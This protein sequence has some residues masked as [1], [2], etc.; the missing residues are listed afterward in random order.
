M[1]NDVSNVGQNRRADARHR[2]IGDGGRRRR[3]IRDGDG[4]SPA[5]RRWAGNVRA[6]VVDAVETI[7]P[8]PRKF[9]EEGGLGEIHTRRPQKHVVEIRVLDCRDDPEQSR[10]DLRIGCLRRKPPSQRLIHRH[11]TRDD[12][13]PR[14]CGDDRLTTARS[15]VRFDKPPHRVGDPQRRD[16]LNN[17]GRDQRINHQVE[18]DLGGAIDRNVFAL[19]GNI[20]VAIVRRQS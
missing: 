12:E 6:K 15:R 20:V 11:T 10:P 3:E 8:R 7:G 19:D 17:R 4:R 13:K 1:M 14:A 2:G 5:A 16:G 9:L 18:K